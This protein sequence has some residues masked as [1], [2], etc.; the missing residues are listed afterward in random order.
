MRGYEFGAS[1]Q[2]AYEFL[3]SENYTNFV[4]KV[5]CTAVDGDYI[6]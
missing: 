2:R 3:T 5:G 6:Y 4:L 1:L